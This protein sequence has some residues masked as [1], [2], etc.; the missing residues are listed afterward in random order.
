MAETQ[1]FRRFKAVRDGAHGAGPKERIGSSSAET[2]QVARRGHKPEGTIVRTTR[3]TATVARI[4]YAKRA[5][6]VEGPNGKAV[7]VHAGPEVQRFNEIKKGDQIV[8]EMTERL[9]V[10][11]TH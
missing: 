11:V 1:G 6:T 2:V 4:D 3:V 10:S 5:V 9:A 7:V 8:I